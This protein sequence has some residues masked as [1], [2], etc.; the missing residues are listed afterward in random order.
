MTIEE[1]PNTFVGRQDRRCLVVLEHQI[2]RAHRACFV[3]CLY[4]PS[5]FERSDV[6]VYLAYIHWLIGLARYLMSGR[7]RSHHGKRSGN[8]NLL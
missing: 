4:Y 1:Y 6:K 2:F 3:F 7:R 5:H 8:V